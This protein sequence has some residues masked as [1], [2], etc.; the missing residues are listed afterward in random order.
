MYSGYTMY[1]TITGYCDINGITVNVD[2]DDELMG[3]NVFKVINAVYQK[4]KIGVLW[5]SYF[6]INHKT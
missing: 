5:S 2:G 3:R 6:R 4:Y 1:H